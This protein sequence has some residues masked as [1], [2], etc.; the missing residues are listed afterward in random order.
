MS[1]LGRVSWAFC[2][3][4]IFVILFGAWVRI[5]GS[6]AGCGN[7]W[8]TCQGVVIPVEPG[9]KT[10]I[11]FTH[12]LTSGLSGLWGLGIV[13]WAWRSRS[14]ALRWALGM[15]FFLLVEGLIGAVLVKKELVDNDASLSRA[16]VISLHLVNTML[17]MLCAVATAVRA[18]GA[19]GRTGVAGRLIYAVMAALVM[20]NATGAVTALGDTLFPSQP[21]LGPELIAKVKEELSASQ[22]FLVR[23]RIVHPVVA[24]LTA[25]I[26]IG[27]MGWLRRRMKTGWTTAAVALVGLQAVMGLANIWLAAP[28]W[29]QLAHLLG[30]QLVWVCVVAVWLE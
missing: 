5:S 7:H 9:I 1:G 2:G 20:T 10:M 27:V 11:E 24:A 23:L 12:R 4:L 8:P 26:V 19:G 14:A 21:A 29:L 28:E 15:F 18:T 30:A 16:V 6:G 17:L 3:Y 25:A 22:H 13:L